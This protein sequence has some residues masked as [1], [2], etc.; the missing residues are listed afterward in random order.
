MAQVKIFGVAERLTPRRA[1]LSDV[2][3]ACVVEVL[4]LPAGKRAHRFFPLAAEDF[5][6]PADRSADYTIIEL[7]MMSGRSV[8]TRKRLVRSLFDRVHADLGITPQDLE[9]CILESPPENWGF[10]GLHGDE[11]QLGYAVRI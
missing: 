3:H 1:A 10:R 4:G 2:I 5:F 6:M 8:E 7:C 9:V 11:A